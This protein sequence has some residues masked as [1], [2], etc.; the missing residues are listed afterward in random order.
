MERIE[1][2]AAFVQSWIDEGQ[3]LLILIEMVESRDAAIRADEAQKCAE[4]A[5][6]EAY[7]LIKLGWP[8]GNDAA[9]RKKIQPLLLAI[10]QGA[11]GEATTPTPDPRDALIEQLGKALEVAHG[12]IPENEAEYKQVTKAIAAWEARE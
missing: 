7:A 1:S 8:M 6:P 5:E 2:A 9:Y 11:E 3:Y 10:T 4:R 12:W